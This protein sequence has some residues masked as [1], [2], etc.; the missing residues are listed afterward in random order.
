MHAIPCVV[1]SGGHSSAGYS[2]IDKSNGNAFV[3][4]LAKMNRVVVSEYSAAIQA[5]ARWKDV[6]EQLNSSQLIIGGMCPHVGL[7]G[8]TLGGGYGLLQ[9]RY[10]MAIDNVMSMT[11]VTANGARVVLANKTVNPELFWAL[12]GGG[13]G[14]F[15]IVTEME[16][17]VYQSTYSS[18]IMAIAK[19]ESGSK[20]EQALTT[21]GVLTSHLPK[22]LYLDIIVLANRELSIALV[23][24]G[25]YEKMV[26]SVKPILELTSDV[27][28]TNYSSYKELAAAFSAERDY[29]HTTSG[30]PLYT[31]GCIVNRIDKDFAEIVFKNSIPNGCMIPFVHLGGVI[32]EILPNETGYYY[33]TGA[34][35][36]YTRCIYKKGQ[37]ETFHFQDS[38]YTTLLEHGYCVGNYVNDMDRRLQGWQ[39]KYYGGNYQH[40]L[41]VKNKWNP[42]DSGYF[43]FPQEIGSNYSW[44]N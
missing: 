22:E 12:R 42:V 24:L 31:R 25:D 39:E 30:G 18:F 33:R 10:G 8:Y 34:F 1:K 7:G 17:K 29:Y 15:G 26:E 21:I 40:L 36:Y 27:K 3:I 11:M 14:N 4:N 28:Y 37:E 2:T 9:R 38:L 44:K 41:E 35:D 23:Y 6:Y 20:S 43:H 19:F 5:G 32:A 16:F 13:G